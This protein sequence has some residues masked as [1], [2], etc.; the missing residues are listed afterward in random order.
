MGLDER[1]KSRLERAEVF[2]AFGTKL[3]DFD[4]LSGIKG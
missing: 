3:I 4:E 2:E 1:L